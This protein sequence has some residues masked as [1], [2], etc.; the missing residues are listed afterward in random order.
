MTRRPS[1]LPLILALGIAV[2]DQVSKQV[3]RDQFALGESLA[4]IDGFFHLTYIRNTG[5][6]WGLLGGLN[7]YLTGLS[8]VMLILLVVFRR[9]LLSDCLS[10]R[11]ALGLMVGGIV[12]NLMDRIR[13]G[14]VTD[15]LDFNLFGYPWPAFNVAD[16]A[17][18]TGVGL[19]VITSYTTARPGREC[20]QSDTPS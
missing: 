4:V 20:K 18:C 1:M 8:V 7:G 10:H 19:Y 2:T 12:G 9:S 5:A 11:L 16:A 13:L 6:A 17:I 15:F 3:V 14:W